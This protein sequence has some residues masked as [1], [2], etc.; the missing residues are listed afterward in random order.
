MTSCKEAAPTP[1]LGKC[2][3]QF[4]QSVIIFLTDLGKQKP[5]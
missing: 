2:R 5:V 4:N 1:P 3:K